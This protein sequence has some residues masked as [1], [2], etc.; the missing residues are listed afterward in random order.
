MVNNEI[1]VREEEGLTE[2]IISAETIISTMADPE[3]DE[4]TT[5]VRVFSLTFS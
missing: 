2:I 5:M 4:I 1:T 3:V